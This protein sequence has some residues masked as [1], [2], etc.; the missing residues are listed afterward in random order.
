MTKHISCCKNKR[1]S[2]TCEGSSICNEDEVTLN[3]NRYLWG[4]VSSCDIELLI[5]DIYNKVVYWKKNVFKVPS[6]ASGKRYI[7]EVTRLI[8]SWTSDSPLKQIP[9]KANMIMPS[10]LLQKPNKNSKAKDHAAALERRL[11]FW[12]EGNLDELYHEANT[13]QQNLKFVLTKETVANLS[14]RFG[15][16]MENGNINS[17]L[18]LVTNN[19]T[20]GILPLNDEITNKLTEKHP[21]PVR[22]KEEALLQG[23]I[24]KIHPIAFEE[25]DASLI[26]RVSIKTKGGAGPSGM[27]ADG[28]RRILVSKTFGE[29]TEDLQKAIANMTRKICSSNCNDDG[30]LDAFLACRLVPLDKNPGVRPIGIGEV[31]RRDESSFTSRRF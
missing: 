16:L 20:G 1:V 13:I 31:L 24:E 8:S 4:N 22:P 6:G 27:D 12:N 3:Q 26:C 21:D 9:I 7:R 19:M 28:W 10:L 23:P 15:K 29:C 30:S 11:K 2:K 14:K 18:K 17:A 5:N 25:I